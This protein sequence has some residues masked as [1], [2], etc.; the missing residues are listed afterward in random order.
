M[1]VDCKVWV[2]LV[3]TFI[4]LV[5]TTIAQNRA[6]PTTLDGPF[7]PVTRAFDRSL[8]R[9]SDDLPLDHPR[10]KRNVSGMFPE[11]I[12][13]AV[14]SPTSMWV[15]WVT[16]IWFPS[17]FFRFLF[18]CVSMYR[19]HKWDF[20]F[21]VQ[22]KRRWVQMWLHLTLQRLQ[23]KSGMGK[24][25]GNTVIERGDT[26]NFTLSFIHLKGFWITLLASFTM[27]GLMVT[28]PLYQSQ[29]FWFL[30][31]VNVKCI[32]VTYNLFFGSVIWSH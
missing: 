13:L 18:I 20:L 17:M 4:M 14:S 15:T 5:N 22:G 24:K 32:P 23:V 11:Q 31:V 29:N 26:Q 19:I 3:V 10:L 25:E 6:I 1:E 30:A 8:R 21:L 9:G 27:S 12:A 2:L 28:R 16:G 7:E